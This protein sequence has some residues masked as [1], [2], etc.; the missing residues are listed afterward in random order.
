MSDDLEKLSDAQLSEVFA[1]ECVGWTLI[2]EHPI[3]NYLNIWHG[4]DGKPINDEQTHSLAQPSFATAS[5]AVLPFC[6]G[7]LT[8]LIW[9]HDQL[10][11][12]PFGKTCN[13]WVKGDS[14][15]RCLCIALIRAKRV[16]KA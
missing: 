4:A 14:F 8:R 11:Y 5:D 2:G 12:L 6:K 7:I 13:D 9:E 10:G 15:A 1:V 16:Q 3:Y